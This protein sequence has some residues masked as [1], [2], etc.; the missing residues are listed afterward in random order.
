MLPTPL[1]CLLT[2]LVVAATVSLLLSG[3]LPAPPSTLLAPTPCCRHDTSTTTRRYHPRYRI[4]QGQ[5]SGSCGLLRSPPPSPATSSSRRRH[6]HS[7]RSL[8]SPFSLDR[9]RVSRFW[10]FWLWVFNRGNLL[11]PSPA[12]SSRRHSPS[13][14]RLLMWP[15]LGFRALMGGRGRSSRGRGFGFDSQPRNPSFLTLYFYFLFPLLH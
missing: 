12:A 9:V 5:G 15:G 4:R 8:V 7:R 2:S 1:A 6:R 13:P 10:D 14:S 3:V 11:A